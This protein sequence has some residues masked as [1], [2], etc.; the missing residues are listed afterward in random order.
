[1]PWKEVNRMSLRREFVQLATKE[2]TCMREL[3]RRYGISTKTGYKWLHRA[4]SLGEEGLVD[5]SRRPHS[6]PR[7]TALWIEDQ[8]LRL[9]H[10][11]PC[12][13]AR[14]LVKRL[15]TLYGGA[16]PSP[17]TITAI[18]RRH[19]CIDT[20][21]S[22]KHRAW[23]RFEACAPNELWQ[24]D[25]KGDFAIGLARC[26]PLTVLDDHSR[27]NLGLYACSDQTRLTVEQR[28][29]RVFRRYGLPRRMIMD[30]GSPW[31][32]VE[33]H[34]YF[35]QL[36]VWLLRLGIEVCHSRPYHPQTMGKDE[37][38]HRTLNAE[39]I[40]GR[41]FV[42]FTDCQNRFD[43]WRLTYNLE[44]PHEALGWDVPASHYQISSRPFPDTLS[45]IEY[46]PDDIVR[47]VQQDG[48]ISFRNREFNI[49]KAFRHLPVAIRATRVDGH[50]DVYF[51]QQ[52]VTEINLNQNSK[53]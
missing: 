36:S 11:H 6:S 12:W 17:S 31:G 2:D 34:R 52:K 28:L 39:V 22:D 51:C 9:R 15:Q 4:N 5:Q 26:H 29:I 10:E 14:K 32:G 19:G 23:Q 41:C 3:C 42:D 33:D 37:R 16:W 44:R 8:I 53:R 40:R 7:R 25:F 1:M 47:K 21:E 35:T 38:F 46:G 49:G 30:N 24:M 27:F 43:R 20:S 13:G 48:E 50:F 18:L 45:P